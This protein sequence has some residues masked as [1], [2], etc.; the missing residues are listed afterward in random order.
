MTTCKELEWY[1]KDFPAFVAKVLGVEQQK[2]KALCAGYALLVG[3][4]EDRAYRELRR[5]IDTP[6]MRGSSDP[7]IKQPNRH[8][9]RRADRNSR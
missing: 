4:Q 9:R 5:Y 1:A 3:L 8:A 6:D 7:S 2:Y